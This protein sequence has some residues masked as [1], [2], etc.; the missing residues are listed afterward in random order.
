MEDA[1]GPGAKFTVLVQASHLTLSATYGTISGAGPDCSSTCVSPALYP[2]TPVT[3]RATTTAGY[4]F[5]HWGGL[6]ESQKTDVCTL[7]DGVSSDGEVSATFSTQYELTVRV[8]GPGEVLV[9]GGSDARCSA[10]VPCVVP[11]VAG[12]KVPV[13]SLRPKDVVAWAVSTGQVCQKSRACDVEMNGNVT[14][15]AKYTGQH[16]PVASDCPAGNMTP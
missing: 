9:V 12:L 13:M 5:I 14:V 8:Q 10:T 3:L 15:V 1:A 11:F 4:H 7:P 6:C 16:C 2:G